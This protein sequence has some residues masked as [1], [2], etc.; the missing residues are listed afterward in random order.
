MEENKEVEVKQVEKSQNIWGFIKNNVS[1]C[2]FMAMNIAFFVWG[3][4]VGN[5][6]QELSMELDLTNNVLPLF[7]IYILSI[8]LTASRILTILGVIFNIIGL[9]IKTKILGIYNAVVLGLFCI[10]V[11]C[12]IML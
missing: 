5:S 2:I 8:V 3:T 12:Q 4:I 1:F 6:M 11:F 10:G 9:K 7:Y